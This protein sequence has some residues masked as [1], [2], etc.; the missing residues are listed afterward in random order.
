MSVSL[1]RRVVAEGLGSVGRARQSTV[2][3]ADEP[4]GGLG[5]RDVAQLPGAIVATVLFGWL[6][7]ALPENASRSVLSEAA[8][9]VG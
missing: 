2:T 3:A 4:Q 1:G 7:P 9:P 5:W 6:V 8:G